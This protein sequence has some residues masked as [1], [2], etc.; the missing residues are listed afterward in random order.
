ALI[1][2]TNRCPTG[3]ATQDPRLTRG[4]V[5]EDKRNRVANYHKNT[6]KTFVELMGA[7]GLKGMQD[8][9]RSHVYRRVSMT[10]MH[11]FEEIFPS[12]QPGSFITGNIPEKYKA[13]YA[14]AS[15][16]QWGIHTVGSWSDD[17]LKEK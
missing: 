17:A 8:I 5:V 3:V 9:T 1:C 16:D 11:T 13:D 14:Y 4:L 7:A 2:N 15:E 6:V 10:A 12:V